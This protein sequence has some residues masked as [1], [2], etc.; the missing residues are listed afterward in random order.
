MLD[1]PPDAYRLYF[2]SWEQLDQSMRFNRAYYRHLQSQAGMEAENDDALHEAI[3]ECNRIYYLY[4]RLKSAQDTICFIALRRNILKM[5]RDNE[6]G[7]EM[8][9][10][11]QLPPP[12]PLHLLREIR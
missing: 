11:G 2:P 1:A 7:P 6:L 12:I 4:D 5:I 8:F 9:A 10:A 3:V